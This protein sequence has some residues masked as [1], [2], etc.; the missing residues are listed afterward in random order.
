VQH[1]DGGVGSIGGAPND[2]GPL[3]WTPID[4]S[5]ATNTVSQVRNFLP[6][7]IALC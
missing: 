2:P 1:R 3:D 7:N 5:D 6:P 4:A